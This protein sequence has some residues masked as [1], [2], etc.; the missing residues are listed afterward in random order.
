[1]LLAKEQQEL[2]ENGKIC[3]ICKEKFE[4]KY[5]KDKEYLKVR[6]HC[7]YTGEYRG[8]GHSICNLKNS[9]LKKI[10]LVFHS[11]SN[12]DYSFI[13]KELE[14]EFKEPFTCLGERTEKYVT[15]AVPIEKEVTRIDK[16]RE[17]ITE[18]ISYILQF[19]DSARFIPR[20]L[21]NLVNNLS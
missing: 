16:K 12:C 5:L 19:I 17:E 8:A 14:E 13:I 15:F 11:R 18:N 6:D 20:S 21:S 7:H 9:V 4:N 2:Y 1:M 3:Y 10:P